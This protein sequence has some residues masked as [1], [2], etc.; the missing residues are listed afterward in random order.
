MLK[1]QRR[2]TVIRSHDLV[3][4]QNEELYFVQCLVS[5]VAV[6]EED[7]LDEEEEEGAVEEEGGELPVEEEEA[8]DKTT[9]PDADTII[10]FT[11]PPGTTNLGKNLGYLTILKFS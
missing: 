11:K 10:L 3:F 2:L 7:E 5:R 4:H 6:C 8:S 9:S 1:S